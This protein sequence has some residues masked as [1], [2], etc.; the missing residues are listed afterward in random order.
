MSKSHVIGLS[1]LYGECLDL[2]VTTKFWKQRDFSYQEFELPVTE[3]KSKFF[4]KTPAQSTTLRYF[5]TQGP[6]FE[7]LEHQPKRAEESPSPLVSVFFSAVSES[8]VEDPDRNIITYDPCLKSPTTLRVRVRLIEKAKQFF[9]LLEFEPSRL[10]ADE[11]VLLEVEETAPSYKLHARLFPQMSCRIVLLEDEN[12]D[13]HPKI[14]HFG[15]SGLSFIVPSIHAIEKVMP[16]QAH[17]D[18]EDPLSI[19][20]VA[21]TNDWGMV[22]EF[23]EIVKRKTN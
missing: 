17:Q 10:D 14:D 18:F 6:G 8:T 15:L 4:L 9:N 5:K 19:K 3:E 2:D 12:V 13:S 1:H 16:L 11:A 21:F 22:I 20:R 7:F 23:L